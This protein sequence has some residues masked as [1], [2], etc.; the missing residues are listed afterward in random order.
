[1]TDSSLD[2]ANF[3][4]FPPVI[5]YPRSRSPAYCNGWCRL[6]VVANIDQGLRTGLGG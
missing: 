5:P 6:E 4:I 2:R 1:M 3:I